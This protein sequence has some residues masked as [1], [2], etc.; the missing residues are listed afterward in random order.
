MLHS[1]SQSE[2]GAS[3]IKRIKTNEWSTPRCDTLRPILDAVLCWGV[4]ER[5][6]I[7]RLKSTYKTIF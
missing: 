2:K 3:T 5:F 1:N 4:P 7:A 6:R